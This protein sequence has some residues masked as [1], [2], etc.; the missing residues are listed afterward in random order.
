MIIHRCI[1]IHPNGCVRWIIM[2]GL[3]F[4]LIM[5][6]LIREILMKTVLDVYVRDA[7]IKKFIYPDVVTM[8]L[9]HKGS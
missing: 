9:P 5:H 7:K 1:E 3:R 2:M 8:H 4:L 6:Y